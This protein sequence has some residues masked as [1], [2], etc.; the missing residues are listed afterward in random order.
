MNIF[1]KGRLGFLLSLTLSTGVMAG[2]PIKDIDVFEAGYIKCI[3]GGFK[4]D[5]FKNIFSGRYVSWMKKEK[6]EKA[7]F[8]SAEFYSKWSGRD[9]VYKVH[10]FNK[11]N[12]AGV[13]DYRTY[14]IERA[15]GDLSYLVVRY[16]SVLGKW[17]INGISWG[18]S[19]SGFKEFLGI[20]NTN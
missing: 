16:R 11:M 9:G 4:D 12:K 10:I 6:E 19:E 20:G 18:N 14:F 7:L 8:D 17:F 1:K 13:F 15:D 2:E 5:C 3:E